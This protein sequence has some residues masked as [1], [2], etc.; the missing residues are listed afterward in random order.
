MNKDLKS[1]DYYIGLDCGTSSVG[2]A[3][4]DLDYN[5]LK[6]NGKRM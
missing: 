2:F 4:T 5:I 6:F 3:V 1:I